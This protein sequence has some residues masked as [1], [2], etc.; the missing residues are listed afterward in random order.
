MKKILL[1]LTF[2]MSL[3]FADF[4][5]F[6]NTIKAVEGPGWADQT[7][8]VS[9]TDGNGSAI[10][11]LGGAINVHDADVHN[12]PVNI[13]LHSHAVTST[14][15]AAAVTSQDTNITVVDPTGFIVGD[16]VKIEN[17]ITEHNLPEITAVNGSVLTLDRPLDNNFSIGATVTEV[18]SDMSVLGSLS[19]PVSYI[20][21]PEAGQVWHIQRILL[22]MTHSTAGD[23]GLFGNLARLTNGVLLRANVGGQWATYTNWKT[24]ADIKDDMYDVDFDARSTGGGTYGTTGRGSFNRV[25]VTIRLDGDAGDYVEVLI[26]DNLT[27][28]LT[29]RIKAQG[30]IEGE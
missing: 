27:G 18:E 19:T 17:G 6:N 5:Y 7:I 22:S 9:L 14:T 25:G 15:L 1:L 23:L 10:G 2:T 24:N 8:K 20:L 11:S 3:V 21:A 12:I 28:L 13:Y 29:F 16:Q 26:Q 30:H 4:K